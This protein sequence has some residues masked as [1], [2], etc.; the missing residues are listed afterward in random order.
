MN[1]SESLPRRKRTYRYRVKCSVCQK[2]ID[3]D[4]K[5]KHKVTH[6]GKTVV[7][8]SVSSANDPTQAKLNFGGPTS[9]KRSLSVN[10]CSN[11]RAADTTTELDDEDDQSS[12]SDFSNDD[13]SSESG[14]EADDN[15]ENNDVNAENN[16][17]RIAP[18]EPTQPIL[19]SY[20]PKKHGRESA[21]RDFKSEWFKVHPWLSYNAELKCGTC[22]SCEEFM[23]N[24]SFK[25]DNWKKPK[26]LVKHA[27]SKRHRNGITKWL[28]YKNARKN[29]TNVL[30]QLDNAHKKLASENRA[31]LKIVIECLLYTAQQNIAQRGS[32]EERSNI[33]QVS[34]V[35][36]GNFLEL[37]SMRCRD[38]TWLKDKLKTQ[39]GQHRQWTSP[40]ICNELLGIM[41]KL[42]LEMIKAEVNDPHCSCLS[43]IMDETSDISKTE[44]V[45][46]C[47]RYIFEG[48]TK[49]TFIGFYDTKSTDGETL[50]SLVLRVFN[51][52]DLPLLNVVGECFDGASNMN[53]I[54]RGLATR[55]KEC[56]PLAIY[57]H[58]FG[59]LLNLAI[60][61]TMTDVPCL[62][63]ALGTIQSLYNFIEGS[64]KRHAVFLDIKLD[65]GDDVARALKSQSVTRWACRWESVKAVINQLPRIM[66]ALLQL[67]KD[68]DAKTY[69]DSRALL[70]AVCDFDFMFGLV[71]LK[72]ILSNT[73]SLSS[74]LQCKSIDV[75]SAK[76]NADSTIATLQKC[77]NDQHFEL[78]WK[79]SEKLSEDVKAVLE[80]TAREF[81]DARLPRTRRA[82]R[83]L[84]ALLGLGAG[85]DQ[86]QHNTPKDHYRITSYYPSFDKVIGEMESRFD[87]EDQSVLC[88]LGDVVLNDNPD[89]S[90][91]SKVAEFYHMDS[92]I[93]LVEKKNYLSFIKLQAK[94]SKDKKQPKLST[95]AHVVEYMYETDKCS[96]L[97]QFYFA[98]S[99]LATIPATSCSAERAFSG[100]RRLKTY[101]RNTM[102]QARLTNLA[103]INIERVFSNR[104]LEKLDE[105]V[106]FFAGRHGRASRFF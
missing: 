88:A 46:M 100:L 4:Y 9:P 52:L 44:Q 101:L 76:K 6:S 38:I 16:D 79:Q 61:D 71:V 27:N 39:L 37:L 82:P 54:H 73:S 41:S 77:R 97:T 81:K 18:K 43:L 31:Y 80:D 14:E 21:K 70:N 28:E 84:E 60:Q 67:A 7:F 48:K 53:G 103:L 74:Y 11:Q 57:I 96:V 65:D 86:V 12:L 95:A 58:C 66:K 32:V 55:M 99:I 47:L 91:Y 90:S 35:N 105:I 50:Y 51:E 92:E 69:T 62:R 22:F 40:D 94:K 49:E 25:F 26:G 59:H 20:N 19:S 72:V 34:D 13:L 98:V 23:G 102:G 85:D 75:I 56:S 106:D 89:I 87:M 36:R 17:A 15:A 8:T 83:R 42:V 24:T 78:A 10:D 1:R 63:N 2:E 29:A 33:H 64:P 3:S 45:A 5:G 104:L 68:R 93:L 30:I